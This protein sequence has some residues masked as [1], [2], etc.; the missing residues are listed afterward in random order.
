MHMLLLVSFLRSLFV[1]VP[2]SI[3][4]CM[5]SII[6]CGHQASCILKKAREWPRT[7]LPV[8]HPHLK[9]HLICAWKRRRNI[10]LPYQCRKPSSSRVYILI[11]GAML[12]VSCFTGATCVSLLFCLLSKNFP[13]NTSPIF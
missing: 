8:V 11:L 1:A 6:A 2:N 9:F 10:H 5:H 12:Q 3:T 7:S 4:F 13:V